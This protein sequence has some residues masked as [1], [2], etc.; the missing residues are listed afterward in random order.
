MILTAICI[1]GVIA[2]VYIANLY[3]AVSDNIMWTIDELAEH[4][5]YNIQKYIESSWEELSNLEGKFSTAQ[6]KTLVDAETLMNTECKNSPYSHLYLVGADGVVY[7]DKFVSYDPESPR[8]TGKL[9]LLPYFE[10]DSKRVIA[11]FDDRLAVTGIVKES[12]LYGIRLKDFTLEGT[13]II[14]LVGIKDISSIQDQMLI[15]SFTKNGTNRGRSVV[16][17]ESGD[18]VVHENQNIYTNER[19]NFFDLIQDAQKSDLSMEEVADKMNANESF[20]FYFTNADGVEKL[21][22]CMPFAEEDIPWYFLMAVE[23]SVFHERNDN[24]LA[25]SMAMMLSTVLIVAVLLA[26]VLISHNKVETAH[27]ESRARSEFLAN[28]SHDIR[29][30]LN[31]IIGLIFLARK[32]LESGADKS[33]LEAR[34]SKAKD[35]ADYLLSLVNNVLDMS[36]LEADKV[37][38]NLEPVSPE[39]ISDAIWSMQKSNLENHGVN[40]SVEKDITE[41][42]IIGDDVL[43]KRVLM[44]IVGNAAKY[45]PKGGSIT[46]TVKQKREDDHHVATTFICADTGCG[47]TQDFLNH[48]WDRY[49][50]EKNKAD[51]NVKSTGLGMAISKLMVDAMGGEIFVESEIDKGSTFTVVLHSEIA[52]APTC[53]QIVPEM[54]KG[55]QDHPMKLLVA[56]DNELNAELLVEILESEGFQVICASDGQE[57]VDAFEHTALKEVDAILMDM[58]MPVMDGCEAS[59]KIRNL[60]RPDAKTVT[61]FACTANSFQDDRERAISSGMN[62]FITKPIDVNVLMKKLGKVPQ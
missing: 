43:I 29:T 30:P 59:A 60:D 55:D 6:C 14:G 17:D 37:E 33:V 49:S 36:K 27:A 5:Q 1:I 19:L 24:Y 40:F 7:S 34:L 41:P 42:W 10:G 15:R 61:I 25:M 35:T 50:Q 28:M 32:D 39:A 44:N 12:I 23:S 26:L 31:G 48:I 45:T 51:T 58:Q 46:L 22:Y 62:D 11:R 53:A 38:L 18:Y 54:E 56:E 9:D 16:V 57:A 47:M 3:Q 13:Q 8:F 52:E 4:D 20:S 21:V 2:V